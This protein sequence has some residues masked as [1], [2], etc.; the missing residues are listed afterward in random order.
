MEIVKKINLIDDE[1]SSAEANEILMDLYNK[2]IN[3][4]KIQNFSS[5]IR[6]GEDDEKALNRIA[7]LKESVSSIAEILEEA[8]AQNKKLKIKSFI[9]IEYED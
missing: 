2:N 8:K 6:F 9:E 3:F 5:Q 1:F 4:N 7:Q